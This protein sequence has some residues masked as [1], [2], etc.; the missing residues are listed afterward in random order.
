ME[1]LRISEVVVV[2]GK[3]DATALSSVIDAL[4]IPTNGFAI[5]TDD[6]KK[7][8]LRRLGKKRGLLILTDSDAAGFRIRYYIEK[9]ALGCS[10][11][12]AYIP[13]VSGKEPR[14]SVPSKEGTLGVEGMPPEML[15]SVLS[16]A[17]ANVTQ[18]DF[19]ETVAY[20]D[21]YDMGLSGKKGSVEL[22]RKVLKKM[23]LPPRLSK[24]ALC[25]VISSLYTK[26]EFIQLVREVLPDA[27]HDTGEGLL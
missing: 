24:R 7:E 27:G 21:L 18:S 10:I 23:G 13:A 14:K 26:K 15:K 9:I 4:I 22:R 20:I 8:L 19:G 3:Y 1:K 11:K 25:Q 12:N 6:E 2:E 5:F 16:A 17:G